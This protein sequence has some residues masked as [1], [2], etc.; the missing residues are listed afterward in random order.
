MAL[1][2][3]SGVLRGLAQRKNSSFSNWKLTRARLLCSDGHW[4]AQLPIVFPKKAGL[5]L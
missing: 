5:I 3:L 1:F 2:P 4:Q